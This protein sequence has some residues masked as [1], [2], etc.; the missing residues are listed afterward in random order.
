MP[1]TSQ[2]QSFKIN[3]KELIIL[4]IQVTECPLMLNP[5]EDC[6]TRLVDIILAIIFGKV[7]RHCFYRVKI[8]VRCRR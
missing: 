3:N 1:N 6:E 5:F 8:T 4:S 7:L 2:V